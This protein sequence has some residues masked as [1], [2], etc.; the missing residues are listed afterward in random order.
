MARA[1][2]K[3]ALVATSPL[4]VR[5]DKGPYPVIYPPSQSLGFGFSELYPLAEVTVVATGSMVPMALDG[6]RALRNEGHLVGLIDITR[7][8]PIPKTLGA[9]LRHARNVIVV[10]DNSPFGGLYS[11]ILESEPSIGKA[12]E[13]LGSGMRDRQNFSYG[14]RSFLNRQEGLD[15]DSLRKRLLE[16]LGNRAIIGDVD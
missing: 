16:L 8:S 9:S 11:A 3:Y 12:L 14:S 4:Y 15:S 10:E 2:A 1:S 13:F 7:V 5:L 6:V